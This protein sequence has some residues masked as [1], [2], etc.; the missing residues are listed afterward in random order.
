MRNRPS[1]DDVREIVRG[2]SVETGV[3]ADL[4]CSNGRARTVVN[5]RRLAMRRARHARASYLTISE[6][7]G[8]AHTSVI[9]TLVR[10][11]EL[12]ARAPIDAETKAKLMPFMRLGGRWSPLTI[13]DYARR[14]TMA[15][16]DARRAIAELLRIGM[17]VSCGDRVVAVYELT[18]A[19]REVLQ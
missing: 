19:A 9:R 18:D 3:E 16:A 13:D 14:A 2:V 5:A 15:T 6:A 8:V 4:I 11:E 12:D 10:N 17:V 7:L 1:V